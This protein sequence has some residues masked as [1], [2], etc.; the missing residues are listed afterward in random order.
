[1]VW[2]LETRGQDDSSGH[3]TA[4][5][6]WMEEG[7]CNC[8]WADLFS[9]LSWPLHALPTNR[10]ANLP[11]SRVALDQACG[12]SAR[13]YEVKT[14]AIRMR[15]ERGASS[16]VVAQ[17]CKQ[18]GFGET[19][20]NRRGVGLGSYSSRKLHLPLRSYERAFH[21]SCSRYRRQRWLSWRARPMARYR[22]S[23]TVHT[24]AT[25]TVKRWMQSLDTSLVRLVA[26][27]YF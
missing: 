3:H 20:L 10:L 6:W 8:V 7:R 21:S 2:S 5:V 17:A 19:H 4:S 15:Y 16:A 12:Q 9:P 1:M 25:K 24:Y 23:L 22:I 18:G 26:C 14:T 27:P 13:C 11:V